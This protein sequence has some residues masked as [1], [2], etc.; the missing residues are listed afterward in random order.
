M[1]YIN[2]PTAVLEGDDVKSTDEADNLVL[3][4]DGNGGAVWEAVIATGGADKTL[5]NL[6][7]P[8]AINQDLIFD[9]VHY[10]KP[11][12]NAVADSNDGD[13]LKIIAGSK[14]AGTGAGGNLFLWSGDSVGG[15]SG[16]IQISA[17]GEQET[18]PD[19]GLVAIYGGYANGGQAGSVVLN[20]GVSDG[21]TQ[22]SIILNASI[23]S[24]LEINPDA[25][26]ILGTDTIDTQFYARPNALV[27][28][29]PAP[30]FYM[31]GSD[32][33]LGTGD[34]GALNIYS[35]DALNGGKSG[36]LSISA[37][38][39]SSPSV[40]GGDLNLSSGNSQS[41]LAGTVNIA[42]GA[43]DGG[44][45]GAIIMYAASSFG[46]PVLEVTSAGEVV[47]R[48]YSNPP[49]DA[50]NANTRELFDSAENAT[51]NWDTVGKITASA[52]LSIAT[53][54]K[55]LEVKTGTH[56]KIGQATLSGGTITVANT[57]VTANSSIQLTVYTPGGTQGHLSYSKINATSFTINS[58]SGTETSVV[59]WHIIE[60]LA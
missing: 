6:D 42:A 53:L 8:T 23:G 33:T 58:T 45:H 40:S 13:V 9:G 17:G 28:S 39:P 2:V 57:S 20:A 30:T 60:R 24:I 37:G 49:V 26:I 21:G 59:D 56:S 12:D 18:A 43:A 55:G 31:K 16:D 29:D 34:G 38:T 41:G 46:A 36:T 48:D 51:L 35:G 14:T 50:L 27:D 10:L 4:S 5:S 47:L 25:N 19:G 32:K 11:T 22:G 15:P 3:T 1:A 54:G 52:T 44:T 7:S